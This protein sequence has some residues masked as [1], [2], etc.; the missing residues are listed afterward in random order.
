[1]IVTMN[2]I[3]ISMGNVID[4]RTTKLFVYKNTS[5]IPKDNR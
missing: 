2:K 1:M 4:S 3:S 5:L